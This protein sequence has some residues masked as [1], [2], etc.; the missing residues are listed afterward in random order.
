VGDSPI[1]GAGTFADGVV[2]VS[3]TGNGE[4]L[5]RR[6]G[7]HE[8]SALMRH[9][10]LAVADACAAVVDGIEE[11]GLIALDANGHLAMPFDTTL[12]HRGWKLGDGPVET[13]VFR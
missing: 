7:A 1:I 3:A 13:R 10:R 12:M 8:V 11:V 5:M 4:A 9:G 6:C 2:A